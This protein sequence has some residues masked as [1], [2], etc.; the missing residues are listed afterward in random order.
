MVVGC[1]VN[2]GSENRKIKLNTSGIERYLKKCHRGYRVVTLEKCR[3]GHES[4]ANNHMHSDS[5]K[6]RFFVALGKAGDAKEGRSGI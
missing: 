2:G 4:T 3:I 6:R 1:L 5:K